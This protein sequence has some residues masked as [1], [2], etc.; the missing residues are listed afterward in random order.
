M[1]A[2]SDLQTDTKEYCSISGTTFDT[3]IKGWINDAQADFTSDENWKFIA[4]SP[5]TV[6]GR[7]IKKAMMRPKSKG[8]YGHKKG[9]S[10]FF[11]S[12]RKGTIKGTHK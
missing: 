7:K 3:Q 6:K 8:G 12:Q 10:V 4:N 2:F 11:A 1:S 5:L 9:K